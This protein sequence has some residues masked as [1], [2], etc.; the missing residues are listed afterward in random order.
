M[1]RLSGTILACLLPLTGCAKSPPE[2]PAA[3]EANLAAQCK[4]VQE[5]HSREIRLD[6]T[7][8]HD[9]DVAQIVSLADKLQ[10]LNLSQTDITDRG[11]AEICA[12][13]GLEQLRLASPRITDDGLK[14]LARLKKLRHL[15]LIGAPLTDEGLA[16]LQTLS[17]LDSLYLDGISAT[18]EGIEKLIKALPQVHVHIDGGHHRG[19]AQ[20][21]D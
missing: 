3:A 17:Q 6:R 16:H 4:A 11:L 5:G 13:E 20:G 15:H 7:P 14:P 19:D 2:S 8:V 1:G 12:C 21:H 9:A 10:D 18:D